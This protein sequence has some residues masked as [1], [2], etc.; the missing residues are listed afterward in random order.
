MLRVLSNRRSRHLVLI[1]V[2]IICL[3]AA[4]A[5]II[6]VY[7]SST[8]R[9]SPQNK[10]IH[11]AILAACIFLFRIIF[12]VYAQSW[13]Y[14]NESAY[15]LFIIADA[16]GGILY[17]IITDRFM[18]YKISAIHTLAVLA[19]E[20]L[21]TLSTRFAY[22]WRRTAVRSPRKAERLSR[23]EGQAT[24]VQ[25]RIA[26]VGASDMGVQLASELLN[27]PNA[28]YLPVCFFDNNPEKVGNYILHLKVYPEDEHTSLVA[29]KINVDTFVI[30]IPDKSSFF[31]KELFDF[32]K[33][34]G[35]RVMVYDYPAQR[36]LQGSQAKSIRDINIED[37]LTRER[38]ETLGDDKAGFYR[39]QV[40]L[41]T[42]AGGSIGS[43]LCRQL[44]RM[45]PRQLILLD[46]YENGVYDLCQELCAHQEQT[47]LVIEIASV[48][49]KRRIDEVMGL[50]HPGI[51]F[52]AAAHK[53]VPLMEHNPGEAVKNNVFGTLNVVNSAEEHKVKRF[54][55]VSTDKAVNPTNIMGASKRLCEMIIQSRKDSE[56]DFVAVRFGNVLGSNGSVIPLFMRQISHGGPI[57]ITDKRIVRYFMMIPE[58]A[59]LV[60]QTG[61]R[62]EKGD[63]YVLNMGQPVKILDLAENLIRLNGFEPYTD[64]DIVEVG[65][66]PGEKLYEELLV[67]EDTMCQTDDHRI[68]IEHEPGPSREEVEQK[69]RLLREALEEDAGDALLEAIKQTVPSYCEADELNLRVISEAEIRAASLI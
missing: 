19:V 32:Y 63:I 31:L 40:I 64:I 49:D 68:F 10:L 17:F 22:Q 45:A 4:I 18:V 29:E 48:R 35:R 53:H 58:A 5:L 47:E 26:I 57:T 69:L 3:A 15:L 6:G 42:G 11:G 60:L 9:L 54:I 1:L 21:F 33:Q 24:R 38:V 23:R 30:A 16:L 61:C 13:R 8:M 55:L 66:R 56:T 34:F 37:L 2:D 28:R 12:R 59:Q 44:F 65:L 43:E 52:H 62:A 39:D 20:L 7:P 41:V 67:R 51:V 25:T 36:L 14:A 50:Y 46:I 27:E